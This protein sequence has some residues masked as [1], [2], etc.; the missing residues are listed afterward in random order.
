MCV[1]YNPFLLL[2]IFGQVLGDPLFCLFRAV[3]AA[4]ESFQATGRFGV[5]A[6]A[7]WPTPQLQQGRI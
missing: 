5:A 3:P 4:Y 1:F 2:C 6:V 7:G